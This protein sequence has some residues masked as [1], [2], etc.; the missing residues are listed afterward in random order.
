LEVLKADSL[1][2]PQ[3]VGDVF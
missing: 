1:R 3:I 2:N